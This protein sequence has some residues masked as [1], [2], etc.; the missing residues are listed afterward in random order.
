M[1]VYPDIEKG[2]SVLHRNPFFIIALSNYRFIIFMISDFSALVIR[3]RYI[4]FG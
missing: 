4:P 2:L 3:I 1:L